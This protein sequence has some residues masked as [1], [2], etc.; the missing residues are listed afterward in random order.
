MA[1]VFSKA[2]VFFLWR[3]RKML[4]LSF[5]QG[6]LLKIFSFLILTESFGWNP[7]HVKKKHK[8]ISS[9]SHN[10]G[11]TFSDVRKVFHPIK[12]RECSLY[13]FYLLSPYS[14]LPQQWSCTRSKHPN[15]TCRYGVPVRTQKALAGTSEKKQGTN[16]T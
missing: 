12:N 10:H 8:D 3:Q 7:S 9:S 4:F 1:K 11:N 15:G 16:C 2:K 13:L 14:S 5:Q 6:L